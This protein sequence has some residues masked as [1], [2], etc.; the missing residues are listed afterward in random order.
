MAHAS[1][2][3]YNSYHHQGRYLVL[4]KTIIYQQILLVVTFLQGHVLREVIL[5]KT[6]IYQ[7]ILLVE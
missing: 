6:I 4:L 7:Q 3:L 1:V 5:L 2:V